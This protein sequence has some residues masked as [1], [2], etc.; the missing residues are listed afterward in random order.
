MHRARIL[1]ICVFTSILASAGLA[2]AADPPA[3]TSNPWKASGTVHDKDQTDED[4]I[5]SKP[6]SATAL[7]GYGTE[8][9]KLGVGARAGYTLPM[10]IYVGG[11]FMYHFGQSVGAA[12]YN[13]FY[14][15]GEAGY[16]IRIGRGVIRPYAGVGPIFVHASVSFLGQSESKTDTS[17]AVYPGVTATYDI[18]NA[19]GVYVGGDARLLFNTQGGDPSFG[20]FVNAGMRF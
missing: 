14:P 1:G 5:A 20:F 12:S 6:I 2:S 19:N 9:L 15:A 7:F 13:V 18:P 11:T 16:D 10:N 8:G 3:K 4:E 17:L